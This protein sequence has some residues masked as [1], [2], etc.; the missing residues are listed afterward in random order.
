MFLS[1][2]TKPKPHHQ[3]KR[4]NV[5]LLV[6]S[7]IFAIVFATSP[8]LNN[9]LNYFSPHPLITAFIGGMLFTSTFTVATGVI[10]LLKLVGF[11]SPILVILL[12]GLGA[13]FCDYLVFIL[14]KDKAPTHVSLIYKNMFN[15]SHLHKILHTHYFAWTLPVLGAII[16]ATPLPDELAISLMSLSKLTG[17]KFV[18][19]AFTSHLVGMTTII[20]SSILF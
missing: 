10:L 16:M 18:F 12:A 20:T 17:F 8:L 19:I 1:P 14:V 3:H 7:L 2:K 15:H 5:I 13:A 6:L 9:L 4:R 11:Y